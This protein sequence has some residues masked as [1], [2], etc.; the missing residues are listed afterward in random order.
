MKT[1]RAIA[2]GLIVGLLV[3]GVVAPAVIVAL[4]PRWRGG[5]VVWSVAV[6]LVVL[7]A[8]IFRL[9]SSDLGRK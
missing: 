3:A 1:I 7:S 6:L 4:P 5:S 2:A 9:V 8:L